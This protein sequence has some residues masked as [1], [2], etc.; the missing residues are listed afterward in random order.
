MEGGVMTAPTVYLKVKV[1]EDIRSSWHT[2]AA[3]E[4]RI[5][6]HFAQGNVYPPDQRFGVHP[7]AGMCSAHLKN[8][9]GYRNM[10]FDPVRGHR[11]PGHPGTFLTPEGFGEV[12]ME[13]LWNGRRREWDEKA[14][15]QMRLTEQICLSGR[16][17]QCD[18]EAA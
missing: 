4:W 16:S 9:Y 14:I 11:W 2:W 1:P 13:R 18:R 7:P 10:R 12:A 8:W 3:S 17:P 5:D 6:Q 15:E